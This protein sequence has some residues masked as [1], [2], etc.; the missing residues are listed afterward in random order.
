MYMIRWLIVATEENVKP[1]I[2]AISGIDSFEGPVTH[3]SLY[4]FGTDFCQK[5]V[6][7]MGVAILAWKLAWISVATMQPLIWWFGTL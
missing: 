5:N 3:T 2:P 6:L 4:K 7:V 1:V